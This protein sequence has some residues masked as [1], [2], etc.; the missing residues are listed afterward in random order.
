M[1]HW[2]QLPPHIL[3]SSSLS[4]SK[5]NLSISDAAESILVGYQSIHC[6]LP[7]QSIALITP[8]SPLCTSLPPNHF[9][10]AYCVVI[11]IL[12]LYL[13]VCMGCTIIGAASRAMYPS[14]RG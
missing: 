2:N 9:P 4:T 1:P 6:P 3:Q 11:Y 13:Y 7:T 8:S 5:L 14:L 10:H 12:V